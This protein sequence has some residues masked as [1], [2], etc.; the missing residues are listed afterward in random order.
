MSEGNSTPVYMFDEAYLAILKSKEFLKTSGGN[1]FLEINLANGNGEFKS[2]GRIKYF[3]IK[4]S[5]KG[6]AIYDDS[7]D[8]SLY[9]YMLKKDAIDKIL[10]IS[11]YQP[12]MVTIEVN[13]EFE[14]V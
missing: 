4:K 10:E 8:S 12:L 9:V 11:D 2:K 7:Q 1:I 5:R 13:P 6:W 3:R 14:P